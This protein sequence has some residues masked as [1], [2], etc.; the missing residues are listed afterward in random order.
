MQ[1][2][3]SVKVKCEQRE[4]ADTG[5]GG[6]LWE[7]QARFRWPRRCCSAVPLRICGTGVGALP[8][9]LL[10]VSVSTERAK[11]HCGLRQKEI[12]VVAIQSLFPF[13]MFGSS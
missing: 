5:L 6:L 12:G 4:R 10:G 11:P 8:L 9:S 1:L 2:V 3:P 13:L 7:E